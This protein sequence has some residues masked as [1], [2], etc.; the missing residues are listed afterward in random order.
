MD[1]NATYLGRLG[2]DVTDVTSLWQFEIEQ[3]EGLS[4]VG[5]LAS[6]ADIS[7]P[8]AGDLLD[9]TRQFANSLLTR[10]T[11][12]P[13]GY[14]WTDNW[15][16]SLAV[17]S[18]GT[19]TVT[20]PSGQERVFQPDS[21]SAAYFSQPGDHGTLIREVNGSFLL[22]EADGTTEAFNGNSTLDYIQDQNGNRVTA[23]YSDGQ[24]VSLSSTSG[25]SLAIGYNAGGT[26]QSVTSSDGRAVDY[27]YDSTGQYLT[28]AQLVGGPVTR[29]TY[30]TGSGPLILHAL[31]G[32]INP[33]GSHEIFGYNAAG[34]LAV[35]AENGNADRLTFSY[36]QGEISVTNAASDVSSYYY[37]DEGNLL[38]YVNAIGNITF[39][40]Y[41]ST[42]DLTSIT[43][44]TGL[45]ESFTYDSNGN[46]TSETNPLG[47]TTSFTY[48][49]VDNLLARMT[50][51]QGAVT[52]FQYNAKGDV[53]SVQY[54]DQSVMGVTYNATG[55][56]LSLT[57]PGGQPTNY[58]YN[59]AGQVAS[60]R[61]DDGTQMTY[62]YNA[63]GEL[64]SATDPSGETTLTYNASGA[65]TG[66]AYPSGESL[67]YNYNGDGQRTQMVEM[68]G[69]TAIATVNY[70]YTSLGQ[71]AGLT[72][73]QGNPIV[74]YTYNNLGELIKAANGDG[75]NTSYTYNADGNVL[76]LINYAAG[77]QTV[78]SSFTY[79]YNALGQVT[80]LATIDGNWTY[81]YDSAGQLTGAVFTS[82]N[83]SIPNQDISYTYNA[84]GDR[85]QT[86]LN[87]V[88]STY[89]SNSDNEYTSVTSPDG[90]TTDTYNANGDL[91]A[92]SSPSGTTTYAYN[93]I[94]QL[95]GVTTPT[96]TWSYQYDALGNVI[97]TT[98]N[99][100]TTQDLV[101]PTG[102]GNLVAQFNSSGALLD[103]Y[104][105][106]LGLVSQTTPTATNYY[107]FDAMGST[108][109]LTTARTTAG[110]STQ[111]AGYSYL[112]FG[113]LLSSTGTAANPFT[114]VGQ[115]G[116]SADG[117]GLYTMG[118]RTYD[119]TTGQFLTNDPTGLGGGDTNLRIYAGNNPIDLIDPSGDASQR[120]SF[121]IPPAPGPGYGLQLPAD[122]QQYTTTP[123]QIQQLTQQYQAALKAYQLQL[124]QYN[125]LPAAQKAGTVPPPPPAYNFPVP[126]PSATSTGGGSAAAPQ[127]PR[128]AIRRQRRVERR[129]GDW[130]DLG[131][132][133]FDR[134][135]RPD[136]PQQL[137]RHRHHPERQ[138]ADRR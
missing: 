102:S 30:S 55:D 114:Y 28:S 36:Q 100:Q 22:E 85:T 78:D 37:D 124:E 73:G 90:T 4:P 61:L 44:A 83:S 3:A 67:Q 77:G 137:R 32:V 10:N 87:G 129:H 21:R 94:N 128:G 126:L 68:S 1:D 112:P 132:Q 82:T 57:D 103:G 56:P 125:Q 14:G 2:E 16:Y 99:G 63:A 101:D 95:I 51:P 52:N 92:A 8:S 76:T 110:T 64:T 35:L 25:E 119:P 34:Q 40:A 59:A 118:A 131:Q 135:Q 97:A 50:D 84:A 106:G 20:M 105:Y 29:Y 53:T 5:T 133:R 46:L 49:G 86:I 66:V 18:D 109:G 47:Q 91:V 117:S 62:G 96:D 74:T 116:V 79:T 93:S 108:A 12:G 38:K 19:V 65:L 72:D 58:T 42:G 69:S 81:T 134:Q 120:P 31:T 24:L 43:G 98:H 60:V 48:S 41:D 33:D 75:T 130:R 26:I 122:Y 107:E 123:A 136:Q 115:Y 54:P 80:G 39:A 89:S 70:N 104:T 27:T 45:K 71:L 6:Q 17:G 9:F 121:Q 15:Q 88:T 113:G 11:L 127:Q 111:I 138:H 23:G 7:V 13:F